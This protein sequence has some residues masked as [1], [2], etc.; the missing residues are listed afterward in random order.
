MTTTKPDLLCLSGEG[1]KE[2]LIRG[3]FHETMSA[4]VN[5]GRIVVKLVLLE[6]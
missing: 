4:G 1:F 3:V 2:E 5:H 6:L